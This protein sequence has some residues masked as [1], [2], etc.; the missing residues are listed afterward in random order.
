[1]PHIHTQPGEHDQTV[2]MYVIRLDTKE[3]TA[4][5]HMHKK[6]HRLM[7]IGGHVELNENPWQAA[8]HELTEESGYRLEYLELLQPTDRIMSLS[9]TMLL[10]QPIVMNDHEYGDINHFHSDISYLFIAHGEPDMPVGEGESTDLRW[11]TKAQ[12][13]E[14]NEPEI[15]QFTKEV[16][17]FAFNVCLDN[18]ERVN[19]KD[20]S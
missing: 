20:F 4:L 1:M 13:D 3:P 5:L 15:I 9:K 17:N 18:W 19:P 6:L 16:Y 7:P 2:S 12:L 10:P 11:M 14:I 8:A